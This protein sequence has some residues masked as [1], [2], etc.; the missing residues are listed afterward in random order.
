MV[1]WPALKYYRCYHCYCTKTNSTRYV[2]TVEFFPTVVQ[3]PHPSSIH[4]ATQATIYL[5]Q[6]LTHPSP[7]TPFAR[8]G[9]GQLR[10]LHLLSDL[11]QQVL[12]PVLVS[13][14]KITISTAD[15][16]ALV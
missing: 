6:A 7:E 16:Q 13:S 2:D 5:S 3:L 1:Y 15:F 10:A 4:I 8:Y 14:Q 9:D 12:P 11:F